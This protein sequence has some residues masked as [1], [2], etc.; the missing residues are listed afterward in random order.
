MHD[1][2]QISVSPSATLREVMEVLDQT[3][4]QIVL[5]VDE[6]QLLLGTCT[7]GDIRRALL[8]GA[9]LE[10]LVSEAMNKDPLVA[11]ETEAPDQVRAMMR[12]KAI[13][14]VPLVDAAKRVQGL[15]L[16]ADPRAGAKQNAQV[17]LM[18]GGLGKRLRPLTETC[19]KPMLPIGGKPLLERIISRFRDQ[20][21]TDF[22]IALNYLGH[23]IEE[24]FGAGDQL[25]V[26]ITYLREDKQLGTAGALALLPDDA[27]DNL[28]VM[29]GDLITELDFRALIEAHEENDAVAT[30]CI[31]EHRT[32]IPFGV[33]ESNGSDYVSTVEKPTIVNHINA[34]IYCISR[35]ALAAIPENSFY[36]MPTLFADLVDAGESCGVFTVRDLWYDIGTNGDYERAKRVFS[37]SP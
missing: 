3:S 13:L 30:M 23:M 12:R 18:A 20:G 37:K 6:E 34:G 4:V 2:Q 28:I 29:N 5:V 21:F 26:N 7:D 31:R 17:V 9:E 24:H 36:D 22:Y 1:I 19:P 25:N 15:F 14:Q 11:K 33:V 32:T 27:A 16:L 35:K 8:A 10:S